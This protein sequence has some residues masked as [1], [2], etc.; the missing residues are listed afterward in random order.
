MQ[1][2]IV[3]YKKYL[4]FV[5]T[6][7]L[8]GILGGVLYY[9]FL[10]ESIQNDITN[11]LLNTS[12]FTYNGT[13]KDLI[14]MSL[15]LVLSFLIIG[16]P[17]AIFYLFYEGVAIGFLLNIFFATFK[18]KGLIYILIYLLINKVISLFVMLFFIYKI[19]NISR[20]LIGLLIYKNNDNI[21]NKIILYFK[22][23]LYLLVIMLII[24]LI[25][26]FVSPYILKYLN[27]LLK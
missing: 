18:L 26:Y 9:H 1:N 24:N 13:I 16:S 2:K 21:K 10:N 4:I 5:I 12:S 25:L 27:F 19:I 15:L 23:A 3:V 22:N 11:T 20:L 6:V 7:V 14:I 8:I 17:L